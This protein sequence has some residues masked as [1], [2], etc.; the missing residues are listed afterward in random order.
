MLLLYSWKAPFLFENP[1]FCFSWTTNSH[2][3][4]NPFPRVQCHVSGKLYFIKFVA[5]YS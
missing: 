3:K 1:P 5:I 2:S 4:P